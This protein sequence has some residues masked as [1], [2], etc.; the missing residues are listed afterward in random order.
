MRNQHHALSEGGCVAA[1]SYNQL[2]MATKGAAVGEATASAGG[3]IRRVVGAG[4]CIAANATEERLSV[5]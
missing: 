5:W 2:A 1:A 3:R 4:A